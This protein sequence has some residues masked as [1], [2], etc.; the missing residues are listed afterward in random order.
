MDSSRCGGAAAGAHHPGGKYEIF[1]SVRGYQMHGN[2]R[3][4]ETTIDGDTDDYA[5]VLDRSTAR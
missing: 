4:I 1:T 5:I 2:P 3:V